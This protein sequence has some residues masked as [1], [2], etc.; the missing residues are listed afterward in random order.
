MSLTRVYL[1]D[2]DGVGL[3]AFFAGLV[4]IIIAL[5]MKK[6]RVKIADLSNQEPL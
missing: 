4:S 5:A 3:L 2:M 1:I 6:N